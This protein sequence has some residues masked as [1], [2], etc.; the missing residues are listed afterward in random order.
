MTDA[1][2]KPKPKINL[3]FLYQFCNDVEEI[4]RFYADKVGK[5]PEKLSPIR[6][7]PRDPGASPSA[8]T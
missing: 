5:H 7:R 6:L 3:R 4:R 8:A 1:K 2:E